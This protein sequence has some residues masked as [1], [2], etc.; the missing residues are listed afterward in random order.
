M[1]CAAIAPLLMLGLTVGPSAW[2]QGFD[3]HGFQVAPHDS[4]L[5]DPILVMRPGAW[6][7]GDVFASVLGEYAE[8]PLVQVSEADLSGQIVERPIL[9]NLVTMNLSAG[10]AVHDRIRIEAKAPMYLVSANSVLEQTEGPAPGDARF[11]TTVLLVRPAYE[12]GRTGGV[13]LGLTGHVDTPTGTPERFL[14]QEGISGGGRLSATYEFSGATLSADVGGQFNPSVDLDNLTGS[15]SLLLGF[16]VG[17]LASDQVGFTAEVVA[18]PPLQPPEGLTFPAEVVGSMRYRD[19]ASG[20][21]FTLGGAGGLTS[22]PGVATYRIFVGGGWGRVQDPVAPDLDAIGSFVVLDQCPLEDEVVNGWRD[23]DGCPDE[24]GALAIRALWRG[25]P[26]AVTALVTGPKG[27]RNEEI[28]VNGM[29]VDAVPGT[30]WSVRAS[31]TTCLDGEGSTVA[32]EGGQTLTV[33]LMQNLDAHVRVEVYDPEGNPVPGAEVRW[34]S[35]RPSCLGTSQALTDSHGVARTPIGE[36]THQVEVDAD[37]HATFA[38]PVVVQS[39]EDKVVRVVL[40]ATRIKVARQQIVIYDK[41]HFET[42]KAVIK[43]ESFGLL[44][45]VAGIIVTNPDLGR[46]EVAGH[47]DSQGSDSYNQ[48]LSQRRAESVRAY[49][50]KQGVP[51]SQMIPKGYGETSPLDTNKTAEGRETNRRVEFNLIDMAAKTEAD[52]REEGL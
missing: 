48:K 36:G 21:F 10:V 13:G 22:G 2:G 34:S 8:S 14:G 41:V 6:T 39:G 33:D 24:L 37:M 51:E 31:T 9:D 12:V 7:Q 27:T 30:S 43:S 16:G 32:S 17:A 29:Q 1:Q 44:D 28:G 5:R 49:L 15:D 40:K 20:A 38:E 23:E 3:A 18:M 47:T 19:S 50:V 35:E 11:S 45:D 26:T 52:S 25:E 4:D 42:A 46:V